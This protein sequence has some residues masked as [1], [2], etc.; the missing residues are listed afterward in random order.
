M[1]TDILL[2]NLPPHESYYA[3]RVPHL[4]MLYLGTSLRRH[5]YSVG[6]L[7]CAERGVRSDQIFAN[8]RQTAPKMIGF[9]IDTDNL[10]SAGNMSRKLKQEFGP[11]M[12]IIFGGPAS[13]GQP[14]E[15]MRR[16][17]A[18][19]LV[20]G[21]G[22][23][24]ACELADC[25]LRGVGALNDIDGICYRDGDEFVYTRPRSPII[26]L[27]ALPFP[28]YRF[29]TDPRDY[30]PAIISGRGCPFKCTFCFEGRMGNRY[31]HRSPENIVAEI[32]Q[33][34]DLYGPVYISINDDTFTAEPDHALR[35]CRLLQERF[36]PRQ[37][38]LWF[39]EVRVDVVREHPELIDAMVESGAGR[40]QIGVESADERILRQYKRLNVRPHVVEEVVKRFHL[41]GLPSIY[42]GFILGGP[43]ETTE[44]METTL[45]FA[46][47][48]T[49]DV[50]PGSFE[51]FASFL[52]PLAGTEIREHPE[53]FDV[54]VLDPDLL[55]SSN[56]NFAVTETAAL[57]RA[58]I[59]N[60]RWHFLEE[61]DAAI[62]LVIPR[63]PWSVVSTHAY[64]NRHFGV[65][66]AYFDRF[67]SFSRLRD[68]VGMVGKGVLER[69][70]DL[71]HHDLLSRFPTRLPAPLHMENST[72]SVAGGPTTLTLNGFGARIYALCSGKLST[73]DI[74]D[75]LNAELGETVPSKAVLTTDVMDFL[76]ELDRAYAIVFK[77]F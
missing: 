35:V 52:T 43:G 3:D 73:S 1:L 2:V 62:R 75:L 33:L 61:M 48:M 15:I 64:I 10:F 57:T 41:A 76:R 17:A 58:D 42:C 8:I 46:K 51:C 74:I 72:L 44:T 23:Y 29:L 56:F 16:S 21:E 24:T 20:I 60:F 19:A 38:L 67:S 26:D 36:R 70:D 49:M 65:T 69:A 32:E 54:R 6:Y 53:R 5:G 12:K 59:N 68:Y 4:G 14:E 55:T 31:R 39:C 25:L 71:N 50:A 45:A 7:D 27:D 22:E 34:V 66:T 77:D 13:Q 30:K 9:S 63:L 40:I 47:H 11:D 37:D 28:D 18:D